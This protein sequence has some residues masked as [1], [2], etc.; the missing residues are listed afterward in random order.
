M[1]AIVVAGHSVGGQFANRYEMWNKVHDT[2]GLPITYVVAT[3]STYAWPDAVRPLPVGDA[4]P[5][6]AKDGW[7]QPAPGA[8]RIRGDKGGSKARA[9]GQ[10][11][12]GARQTSTPRKAGGS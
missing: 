11:R 2:L 5:V 4:D 8:R 6:K 9:G 12:G 7:D 3:P 1:A 10:T